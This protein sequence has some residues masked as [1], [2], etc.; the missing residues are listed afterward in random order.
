MRTLVA[1]SLFSEKQLALFDEVINDMSH[2]LKDATAGS[3]MGF[4]VLPFYA[5]MLISKVWAEGYLLF[6][7]K[8]KPDPNMLQRWLSTLDHA[9]NS[10]L[11]STLA[12]WSKYV[13]PLI[14][15]V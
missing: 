4:D 2:T 11:Q 3:N 15:L 13:T 5:V 7:T 14:V 8:Q 6:V 9:H 1:N 12:S 10:V